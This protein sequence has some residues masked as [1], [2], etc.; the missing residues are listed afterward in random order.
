[1]SRYKA[2]LSP[3]QSPASQRIDKTALEEE[4]SP[5][6]APMRSVSGFFGP[7]S[8]LSN[9]HPAPVL[10]DDI[11]YPSAEHAF[12]ASRTDDPSL[13]RDIA[14]ALTI[15]RAGGVM[16]NLKLRPDWH[17]LSTAIML[18]ILRA[19]FSDPALAAELVDTGTFPLI[20]LNYWGDRHWGA[21]AEGTVLHGGNRL[22]HCLMQVRTEQFAARNQVPARRKG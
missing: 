1:M 9:I 20:N 19:K 17:P 2:T 18:E 8:W 5:Y 21:V 12:Q 11:L 16:N 6:Y 3:Q 7:R 15:T 10:A 14:K 13:R 4:T 22:G